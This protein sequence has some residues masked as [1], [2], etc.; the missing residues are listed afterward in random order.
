MYRTA[1]RPRRT[2]AIFAATLD[3]LAERGYDALT[4]EA[5]AARAG[6]NKTTIYRTWATKD[7]VL[8]DALLESPSLAYEVPDS[9]CLRDD[10]MGVAGQIA[11]LLADQSTRRIIGAMIG[12]LPDRPATAAATS[13]FFVDRLARE[14]I[15]FQR[16][17]ERGEL[18]DAA[19]PDMIMNLLAGNLWFHALIHSRK[20]DDTYIERLVDTI[21]HGVIGPEAGG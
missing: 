13:S 4:V 10:L 14:Q 21:L 3:I 11:G 18:T 6:V 7:Q 8:A 20:V 9:G 12:S 5:V 17:R 19:D 16:A 2:D 1:S 15:I